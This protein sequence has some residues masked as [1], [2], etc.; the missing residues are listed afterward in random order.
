[1]KGIIHRIPGLS[2]LLGIFL[3]AVASASAQPTSSGSLLRQAYATLAVAD[4]DYNGHRVEAMHQI[5]AAA[6]S[7]NL[8]IRG[9]GKGHE[10]QGVSDEQLRLAKGMLE[11][12][13]A[14]LRGKA[15]KH[16][17]HAIRQINIALRI[18]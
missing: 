5:E 8:E 15:L 1:M 2:V 16:I 11:Q 3:I 7:L 10:H 14:S 18:R 4:H 9:D 17:D 12:A 6:K 13:R